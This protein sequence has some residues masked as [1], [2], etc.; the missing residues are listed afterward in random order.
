MYLEKQVK[1]QVNKV[2]TMSRQQ[3][4]TRQKIKNRIRAKVSWTSERPRLS[5]FRSVNY[6][7]AQLIDDIK[8]VTIHSSRAVKS[9]KWAKEVWLDIAKKSWPIDIVFDRNWYLYTWMIKTLADTLR[10]AWLKF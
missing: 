2:K 7:S 9:L 8:W 5:V 6:I 3:L 10:E 1:L 4:T